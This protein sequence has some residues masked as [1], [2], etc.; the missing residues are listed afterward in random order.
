MGVK[1]N[2][3]YDLRRMIRI[4]TFT[5]SNERLLRGLEKLSITEISALYQAIADRINEAKTRK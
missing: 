4:D 1:A 2:Y 3:L 5:P